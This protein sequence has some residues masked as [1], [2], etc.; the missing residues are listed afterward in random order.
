[1]T[2]PF[3]QKSNEDLHKLLSEKE[4]ALT[5]FRF[6]T[7]GAKLT[8]VRLG[9]NLRRDIARIKTILNNSTN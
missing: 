7:S 1:M 5:E 9:R 3:R 4:A 6:G 8:D 2:H